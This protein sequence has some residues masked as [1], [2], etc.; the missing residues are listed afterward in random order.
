LAPP[1]SPRLKKRKRKG[2]FTPRDGRGR[3]ET[4][5]TCSARVAE[6]EGHML[7]RRRWGFLTHLTFEQSSQSVS[8]EEEERGNK[9]LQE[10]NHCV[11][12]RKDTRE[13]RVP[14]RLRQLTR[15]G[16]FHHHSTLNPRNAMSDPSFRLESGQGW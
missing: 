2:L 10:T 15:E 11:G 7:K 4:G 3:V 1:Y 12:K 8:K 6:R 13:V 9:L 16:G 14:L 5:N